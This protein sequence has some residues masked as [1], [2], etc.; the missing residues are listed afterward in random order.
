MPDLQQAAVKIVH[1]QH[2]AQLMP[3]SVLF[4][5]GLFTAQTGLAHG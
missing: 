2:T 3:V 1:D 5:H 4:K